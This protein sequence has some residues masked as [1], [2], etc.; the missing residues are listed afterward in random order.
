[1]E[2]NKENLKKFLDDK[3]EPKS[4]I[5]ET[6]SDVAIDIFISLGEKYLWPQL[7]EEAQGVV[8]GWIEGSLVTA[9][10]DP[11]QKPPGNP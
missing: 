8:N 4:K 1:M 5:L 3:I 11:G 2:L 7:S 10:T 9:K 6:A